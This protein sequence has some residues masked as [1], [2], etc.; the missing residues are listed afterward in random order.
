MRVWLFDRDT[1][2]LLFVFVSLK[3]FYSN[4]RKLQY[5]KNLIT[6]P[7]LPDVSSGSG[8]LLVLRFGWN[9]ELPKY[10]QNFAETF[11]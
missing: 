3:T 7:V 2:L 5:F 10:C 11:R 6:V 8:S 9:F 1:I 4:T